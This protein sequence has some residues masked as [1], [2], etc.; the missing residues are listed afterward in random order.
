MMALIAF[1][2]L[3][4]GTSG[5]SLQVTN[6]LAGYLL[7]AVTFLGLGPAFNDGALFRVEFLL[8]TLREGPRLVVQILFTLVALGFALTLGF[9]LLRL[10]LQSYNQGF[11]APTLLATPLFLPQLIMPIGAGCLVVVLIATIVRDAVRLIR[12][13]TDAGPTP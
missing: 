12:K 10:V 9:Q 4:R 3:V 2:V 6:E 1:E 13:P 8:R 5:Y 7:V 11:E